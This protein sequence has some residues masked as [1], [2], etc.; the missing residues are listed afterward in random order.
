MKK[1]IF[2]YSVVSQQTFS[3][4]RYVSIL[5]HI[6]PFQR[7][8]ENPLVKHWIWWRKRIGI[9]YRFLLTENEQWMLK[10]LWIIYERYSES[11]Y[12]R[13]ERTKTRETPVLGNQPQM[14]I[15]RRSWLRGWPRK[16][17]LSSRMQWKRVN[18]TL[19]VC[20]AYK[21]IWIEIWNVYVDKYS[22]DTLV[23]S[24]LSTLYGSS[25][26]WNEWITLKTFLWTRP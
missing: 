22:G 3:T 20:T 12:E 14:W 1:K 24:S 25:T 7:K 10:F 11:G 18:H 17:V 6:R 26:Q 23:R 19:E 5:F 8:W 9:H 13:Y 21:A 16:N 15:F 4:F 2:H